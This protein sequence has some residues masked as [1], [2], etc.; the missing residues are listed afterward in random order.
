MTVTVLALLQG[1]GRRRINESESGQ[2]RS[3]G[4]STLPLPPGTTHEL[5][6]VHPCV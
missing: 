3:I 2:S 5:G 4:G 1:L 6:W